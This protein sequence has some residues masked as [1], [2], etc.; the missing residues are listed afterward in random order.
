M[1]V[2]VGGE[3]GIR[4]LVPPFG[5]H[6]ISSRRRYDHFGTSPMRTIVTAR[7]VLFQRHREPRNGGVISSPPEIASPSVRND[8]TEALTVRR[9]ATWQSPYP[10]GL[11]RLHLT[12]TVPHA[13]TDRPSAASGRAVGLC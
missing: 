1:N 3:E 5:D 2:V 7:S 9:E 4:T 13:Q 11:L 6:P 8:I 12:M 10:S